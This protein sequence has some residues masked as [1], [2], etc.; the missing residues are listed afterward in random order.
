V[1]FLL[2]SI[3]F[4]RN[5]AFLRWHAR[6]GLLPLA[7]EAPFFFFGRS[8]SP[9]A[10]RW[11]SRL[12]WLPFHRLR[13]VCLLVRDHS[14]SGI[15]P[16]SFSRSWLELS[17]PIPGSFFPPFFRRRSAPSRDVNF[18]QAGASVDFPPHLSSFSLCFSRDFLSLTL[19][20]DSSLVPSGIVSRFPERSDR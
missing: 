14:P 13:C 1:S 20:R 8:S 15:S 18:P 17:S 2:S 4:L 3:S 10:S 19:W 5:V 12:R 7:S 9:V 11:F 6:R 16:P